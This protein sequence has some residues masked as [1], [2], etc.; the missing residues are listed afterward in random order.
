MGDAVE[1][2]LEGPHLV[3]G[4]LGGK[5][6]CRVIIALGERLLLEL[7]HSGGRESGE[8]RQNK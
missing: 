5:G 2:L 8:T 3:D 1:E 7:R 6:V 4:I